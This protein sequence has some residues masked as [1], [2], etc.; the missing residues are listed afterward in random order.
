MTY[1]GLVVLVVLSHAAAAIAITAAW[2]GHSAY[3]KVK[4]WRKQ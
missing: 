3:R 2:A 4:Q 1:E